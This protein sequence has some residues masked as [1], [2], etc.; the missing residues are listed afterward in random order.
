MRSVHPAGTSVLEQFTCCAD[1]GVQRPP[2]PCMGVPSIH[3]WRLGWQMLLRQSWSCLCCCAE[4]GQLCRASGMTFQL[5][6][7]VLKREYPSHLAQERPVVELAAG[8]MSV[9]ATATM[10]AAL[11]CASADNAKSQ[12]WLLVWI[13]NIF[14]R[15]WE[16][17]DPGHFGYECP[18][19]KG[20]SRGCYRN[21][22]GSPPFP[23]GRCCE[24][25]AKATVTTSHRNINVQV[26]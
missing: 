21:C 9:V 12:L 5:V 13:L 22:A 17:E 11:S 2:P 3:R 7:Q 23:N 15:C 1:T 18:V 4:N 16:C 6:V 10:T 26:L 20:G 8:S 14:C 19:R 25:L 24:L